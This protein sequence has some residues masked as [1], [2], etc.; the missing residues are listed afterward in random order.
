[1]RSSCWDRSSNGRAPAGRSAR[2]DIRTIVRYS[3]IMKL[4]AIG[5]AAIVTAA[6]ATLPVAGSPQEQSPGGDIPDSQTFVTYRSSAHY[7]VDVPEGWGRSL[8]GATVR[9]ESHANSVELTADPKGSPGSGKS[10][11][12]RHLRATV[13]SFRSLSAANP[14]TGKRVALDN[15]RYLF[16]RA[17]HIVVLTLSA[18][19]GADNAD[20]W[21]R[22]A[23]SFTW[24]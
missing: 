12:L 6:A 24:R 2:G 8:H 16:S 21:R 1:M 18:P 20:Q 9:F 5:L 4:L 3:R 15:E 22:I 19:A 13:R 14:V 11:T 7:T 17:G 10:V 23:D